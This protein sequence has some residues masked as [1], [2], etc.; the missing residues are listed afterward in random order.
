MVIRLGVS[1][2]PVMEEIAESE[3]QVRLPIIE[4]FR[5]SWRP[6][7]QG[8]LIFMGNG[9]AGYMI[10][11]G[12]VLSY[13]VN[14]LDRETTLTIILTTSAVWIGTTILATWASDKITRK[15]TYHIGF[16]S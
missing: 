5:T 15:R 3:E 2:S 11:G 10:A 7:V 13:T 8:A 16:I 14:D 6:L 12:Y 4:M 9:V 1:E